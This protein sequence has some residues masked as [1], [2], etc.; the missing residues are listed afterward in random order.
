MSDYFL[1]E[2][3]LRQVIKPM[4]IF[5]S[6]YMMTAFELKEGETLV[7][8]DTDGRFVRILTCRG[9]FDVGIDYLASS[10]FIPV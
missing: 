7:V 2:G 8:L 6:S 10:T 3:Q 1:E 9:V 5:Y 4:M